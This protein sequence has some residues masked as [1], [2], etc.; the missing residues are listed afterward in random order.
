MQWDKFRSLAD[1]YEIA[2][3]DL[4]AVSRRALAGDMAACAASNVLDRASAAHAEFVA[5]AAK[6]FAGTTD[7]DR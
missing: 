5:E 1:Q 4:I 6:V 2:T 7:Q 3:N